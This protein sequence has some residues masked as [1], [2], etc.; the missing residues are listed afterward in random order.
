MNKSFMRKA[1]TVMTAG[2]VLVC[3][4]GCGAQESSSSAGGAGAVDGAYY[5]YV[6]STDL[7]AGGATV[8]YATDTT[9]YVFTDGTYMLT[10]KTTLDL[11]EASAGYLQNVGDMKV[12]FGTCTL[13]DED[14]EYAYTLEKPTRVIYSDYTMTGPDSTIEIDVD[15]SKSDT[16]ANY[17]LADITGK[18]E[19]EVIDLLLNT[20]VTGEVAEGDP[21]Y[22]TTVVVNPDTFMIEETYTE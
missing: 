6:T 14:G 7:D 22:I 21:T 1:I 11:T 3:T 10:Q 18:S 17:S 15:S 2:M 19:S 13:D 9:F 4:A 5:T 8:G 12:S 20:S 16:Y